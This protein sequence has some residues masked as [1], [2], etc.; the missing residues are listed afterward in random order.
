MTLMDNKHIGRDKNK[1]NGEDENPHPSHA[2]NS[3]KM[4]A[5]STPSES[6]ETKSS[7]RLGHPPRSTVRG[8]DK[9]KRESENPT[10]DKRTATDGD[11]V[12]VILRKNW[13][14]FT[15]RKALNFNV[16]SSYLNR[17]WW[18]GTRSGPG[19]P[20]KARFWIIWTGSKIVHSTRCVDGPEPR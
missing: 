7:L 3:G 9:S 10:L 1:V 2:P 19:F 6:A 18:K 20:A 15:T 4:G 8:K 5:A 12:Q 13:A 17:P 16:L 11:L 14:A